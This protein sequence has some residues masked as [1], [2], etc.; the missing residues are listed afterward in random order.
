[1]IFGREFI[2]PPPGLD[3]GEGRGWG[4]SAEQACTDL[5]RVVCGV[6]APLWCRFILMLRE[7]LW[8][9]MDGRLS[10]GYGM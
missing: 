1:V 2:L 8:N 7:N 5:V 9:F 6:G 10:N 4:G 3:S